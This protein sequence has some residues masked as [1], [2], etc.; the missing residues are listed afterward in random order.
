[1]AMPTASPRRLARFAGALYAVIIVFGVWSEVAVRSAYFV[2]GDAAA[3]AANLLAH[4]SLFR[5]SFAAD[6][7]M[8]LSDVA[9]AVLLFVLLRPAGPL[10]ALMGMAFRLVQAALIA[11]SLLAQHM[12]LV[13]ATGGVDTGAGGGQALAALL[14]EVHAHGYDLGLVFFGVACLAVGWLIARSGFLP[15]WLGLLVIAAGPVYIV[16][17]F[18]RFFAPDHLGVVQYAY[19]VPVIAETALCL[20]LLVRGV[21]AEAWDKRA[22]ASVA[23]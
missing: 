3:T 9:L 11:V 8:A 10:L 15:R 6:T 5:L 12:A 19:V 17:S 1:M 2:P 14:L 22:R 21:D 16:G 18:T 4:A 13:L 7:V 23:P 20:W